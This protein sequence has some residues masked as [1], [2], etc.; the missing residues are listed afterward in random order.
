[1]NPVQSA[2]KKYKIKVSLCNSHSAANIFLPFLLAACGGGTGSSQ[3]EII[4]FP[5][6]YRPPDSNYDSPKTPDPYA[7]KLYSPYIEPY[8]VSALEMSR[9]EEHISPMLVNYERVV[10]YTFPN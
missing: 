1:M 10:N 5:S 8:W 2:V 6:S 7:E 3:R 9:P 4:G